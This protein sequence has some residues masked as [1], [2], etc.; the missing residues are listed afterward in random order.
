MASV[1]TV[2]VERRLL[3][4]EGRELARVGDDQHHGLRFALGGADLTHWRELTVELL[5]G[6]HDLLAAVSSSLHDAGLAPTSTAQLDRVLGQDHARGHRSPQAP[7][8][9]TV[10]VLLVH[11]A[12]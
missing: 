8:D 5:D 6:D 9:G 4:A 1:R 11:P 12:A 3:D 7:G 10:G 2:R